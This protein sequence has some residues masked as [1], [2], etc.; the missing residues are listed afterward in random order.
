MGAQEFFQMFQYF[1]ATISLDIIAGY[2]NYNLLTVSQNKL[3]D[4]FTHHVEMVN[5]PTHTS[6][7]LLNHV[8]IKKLWWNNFPLMYQL[9]T[10]TFQIMI[11]LNCNSKMLLILK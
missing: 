9:K 5:K 6:E 7:S 4:I 8:Y 10:F 3:L 11:L 1:L 2:F